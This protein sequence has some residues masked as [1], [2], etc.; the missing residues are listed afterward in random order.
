MCTEGLGVTRWKLEGF[1]ILTQSSN[2]L[3]KVSSCHTEFWE[4]EANEREI[5]QREQ[6]RGTKI[7]QSIIK[8]IIC[9]QKTICE[10]Y[11]F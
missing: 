1:G 5:E 3:D 7:S 10:I 11:F 9:R 8:Q 6:I 4:G 2:T